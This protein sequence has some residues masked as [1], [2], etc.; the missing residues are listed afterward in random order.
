MIKSRSTHKSVYV[1][2]IKNYLKKKVVGVGDRAYVGINIWIICFWKKFRINLSTAYGLVLG[3]CTEYLW[4]RLKVQ[5]KWEAALNNQDLLGLLKIIKFLL[6]KYNEGTEYHH[7]AYH[8]L[9]HQFMLL[10]Q[11]DNSNS[12]YKQRFKDNIEVLEAHNGGVLFGEIS[13]TTTREI[14]MLVLN[15]E[16][17]SEVDKAQVSARGK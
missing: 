5:E 4:S 16:T 1:D 6:Q 17:K 9:L 10:R 7:V 15:S 8:T 12:E 11:G 3:Q 14:A 2:L 13:G